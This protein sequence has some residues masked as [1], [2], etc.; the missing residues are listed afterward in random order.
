METENAIY[1]IGKLKLVNSSD[2]DI[3][4]S[5]KK[6]LESIHDS[7]YYVTRTNTDNDYIYFDVVKI[8]GHWYL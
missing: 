1:N 6:L 3:Q 4:N 2:Y 8:I 5:C 7:G